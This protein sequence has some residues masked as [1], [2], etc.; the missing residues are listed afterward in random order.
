MQERLQETL[1]SQGPTVSTQLYT[2]KDAAYHVTSLSL[3]L[4]LSLSFSLSLSLSPLS[5]SLSFSLSLSLSLS[6]FLPHAISLQFYH[7]NMR[8]NVPSKLKH[9]QKTH[10]HDI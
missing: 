10:Y 4:T 1:I 5:L 3:S 6:L 2:S 8:T 7:Q 9:T